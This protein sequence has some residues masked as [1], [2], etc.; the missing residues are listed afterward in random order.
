[1]GPLA[2]RVDAPRVGGVLVVGDAAGFFDPFT[3]E[4]IFKGLR[5][6]ELAAETAVRALRL[7]DVSA[8]ALAGYDR[9]RRRA[10]RDK[11]RLTHALQVVIAHRRLANLT[12]RLLVRRQRL[13]DL[14]LG[15]LGDYVP[16][17]ALVTGILARSR[18]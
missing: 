17:R 18:S 3:G 10:S 14:L 12:A 7:G 2:Y 1:M 16:P 5:S 11:E 13:L 4:G 15:V 9:A 8:Q 6:A